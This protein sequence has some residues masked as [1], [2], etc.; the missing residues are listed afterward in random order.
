MKNNERNATRKRPCP[1]TPRHPPDADDGTTIAPLFSRAFIAPAISVSDFRANPEGYLTTLIYRQDSI[2]GPGDQGGRMKNYP[3]CWDRHDDGDATRRLKVPP[4]RI[5]GGR[6]HD[7]FSGRLTAD[8]SSPRSSVRARARALSE[9]RGTRVA[10]ERQ[11]EQV[12]T[13]ANGGKIAAYF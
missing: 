12:I 5:Y 6:C 9:K 10:Q 4:W 1:A 8:R 7:L 2:R 3:G 13:R 11:L